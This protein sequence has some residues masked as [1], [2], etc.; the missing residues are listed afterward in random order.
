LDAGSELVGHRV[1]RSQAGCTRGDIGG[2]SN[3]VAAERPNCA[4]VKNKGAPDLNNSFAGIINGGSRGDEK[5]MAIAAKNFKTH[6]E[7]ARI[8]PIDDR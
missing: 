1:I 6:D 5:P 7:A 3:I 8:S 4:D 2:R